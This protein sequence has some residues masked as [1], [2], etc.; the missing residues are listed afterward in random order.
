MEMDLEDHA[1]DAVRK[2]REGLGIPPEKVAR[3]GGIDPE[4]LRSFEKEGA[5]PEGMDLEGV[6]R[7]LTLDPARLVA[8]ARGG[9][10]A[11]PDLGPWP[12]LHRVS[13]AK[14]GMMVHCYLVGDPASPRAALFDTGWSV[15]PI[16]SLVRSGELELEHLFIT[17]SHW[18]HV[19]AL[20]EVREAYPRIRLHGFCEGMP[21]EQR[22]DAGDVF[23]VGSLAIRWRESSGHAED[24]VT[25]VIEGY[26]QGAPP[27]AV[28]G[29]AIFDSS[30][31]GAPRHFAH[32]RRQVRQNILS[33]PEGTLICPGHGPMTTVGEQR[34]RN[35]FFATE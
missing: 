21:A 20:A 30:M 14:G 24:G 5:L 15:D 22:L 2:S 7:L 6:A 19:A 27:V 13:D 23:R 12:G 3:R 16:R 28:V 32:A 29:D 8:L 35:P 10:P 34:R 4:G 9:T 31:G 11:A 33:L 1:G 17:H 25:Y 18:D 26:P